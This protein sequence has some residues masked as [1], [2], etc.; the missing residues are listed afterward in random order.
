MRSIA[1]MAIAVAMFSVCA[2]KEGVAWQAAAPPP[3]TQPTVAGVSPVQ[4]TNDAFEQQ[5]LK[6]IAGHEQEPAEKVFKNVQMMKTVPASRF[7]R[8]MNRGYSRALG[9]DC[10]HCHNEKDF[11][12]DEKRPKLAAREMAVM[13]RSINEQLNKMQNLQP[14]PQGTFINCSTCHR[15]AIDPVASDR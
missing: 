8:I 6:Q 11:A 2:S 14:R 1:A 5:I 3:A 4:A 15:G 12:S 7:L 10:K 9:V 13:H